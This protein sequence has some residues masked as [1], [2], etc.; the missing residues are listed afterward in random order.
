[1]RDCAIAL[2]KP[3]VV[4]RVAI[5]GGGCSGIVMAKALL[6]EQYFGDIELFEQRDQIG[7]VW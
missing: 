7:G 2:I 5:I 3:M 6:G 4:K 1:L